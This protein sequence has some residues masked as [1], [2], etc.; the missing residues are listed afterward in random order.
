MESRRDSGGPYP[1]E[2]RGPSRVLLCRLESSG[3]R[4]GDQRG[5]VH[6]PQPGRLVAS[7]ASLPASV[8][9]GPDTRPN[10]QMTKVRARLLNAFFGGVKVETC[11]SSVRGPAPRLYYL[12]VDLLLKRCLLPIYKIET[13]GLQV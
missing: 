7:A 8:L 2:G 4:M 1:P 10:C 12:D 3:W 13:S 11:M 9:P 5:E 6:S